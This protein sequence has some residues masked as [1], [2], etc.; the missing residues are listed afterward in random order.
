MRRT[1]AGSEAAR[2]QPVGQR[3]Q[4]LGAISKR[5]QGSERLSVQQPHSLLRG[6]YADDGRVG[7]FGARA[8]CASGLAQRRGVSEHIQQIVLNL[9]GQTDWTRK[10]GQG[11][12]LTC[13]ER[14][15]AGGR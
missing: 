7:G 14:R 5:H 15:Y 1:K 6:C 3:A 10:T 12:V 9:E 2:E 13:L 11:L 4:G 8:V